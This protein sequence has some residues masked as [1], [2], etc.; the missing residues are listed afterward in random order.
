MTGP[1]SGQETSCRAAPPSPLA[2]P[3]GCHFHPRCSEATERCRQQ[4]P[5]LRDVGENY[6][7]ACWL[8]AA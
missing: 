2:P 5:E 1:G 4:A 6:W 7:V 3:P 8:H